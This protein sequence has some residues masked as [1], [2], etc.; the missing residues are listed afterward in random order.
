MVWFFLVVHYENCSIDRFHWWIPSWLHRAQKYCEAAIG[1]VQGKGRKA[2]ATRRVNAA[3][4]AKALPPVSGITC[5]VLQCLLPVVKQSV[6]FAVSNC[7]M[8]WNDHERAWALSRVRFVVSAPSKFRDQWNA[9]KVSKLFQV[10]TA[11]S[12]FS[13]KNDIVGMHRV[14][15]VWDL[16]VRLSQPE[17]VKL[18]AECAATCC[19][20]LGICDFDASIAAASCARGLASCPEYNKERRRCIASNTEYQLYASNMFRGK[21]E[22][23]V[24][25]DKLKKYMC[26]LCP[27]GFISIYF[28]IL[29]WLR[30][31]GICP[32]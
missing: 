29:L 27:C 32:V 14:D 4:R 25:D 31:L 17:S 13:I 6:R 26:G 7:S 22:V 15:K 2:L 3:L 20:A 10:S 30:G 8:P 5:R 28:G 23:L 1:F 24:P 18:A 19:G 21:N 11:D 16:P 9:P 12:N